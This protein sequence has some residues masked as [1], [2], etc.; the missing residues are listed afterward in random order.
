MPSG[1]FFGFVVA[2]IA[3]GNGIAMGASSGMAEE[4]A[5]ALVQFGADDVF[6]LASL[7]VR[8][9]V[10]NAEGVFEEAFRETVTADDIAGAALATVG[11]FDMA[12]GFD[13][14]QAEIFHASQSAD[15]I[16]AAGRADVLDIGAIPFFFADPDLLKQMVEVN[17]VVH[18]DALINGEVSVN[19][20]N[21]AVGLLGD[22]GIVGD[23]EDGMAS[24]VELAEQ[25]DDDFLVG[26]VEIAGGLVG[27]NE[28]GLIDQRTSDGD[29]LLLSTRELRGKVREAMPQT[30][31]FE[32]VGGLRFVGDAM[33]V[34]R[35][36]HVFQRVEIRDQVELLE[37]EA[38]FLG[39]IT[40]QFVF[41][42]I[43]KVDAVDEN[44]A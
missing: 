11:Q 35:E 12:I 18:G 44:V 4:A 13:M 31:A 26:L 41:T 27:Q 16:D 8:F 21:A 32:G 15:R 33:E 9:V 34:L 37:D 24:A 36:H 28:L 6:E 14:D 7:T 43:G 2:A 23:H 20:L 10:V 5:D 42:E 22:V 1:L 39:T 29:A 40:D 19:K 38:D 25:A 30:D 17:A 3:R